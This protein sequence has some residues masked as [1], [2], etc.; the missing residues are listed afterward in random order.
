MDWSLIRS[1]L[2]PS[3]QL[4]FVNRFSPNRERHPVAQVANLKEGLKDVNGCS[5]T[6][7]EFFRLVRNEDVA[8]SI[9][10]SS[11]KQIKASKIR[12]RIVLLLGI[13]RLAMFSEFLRLFL[14]TSV[15]VLLVYFS[16]QVSSGLYRN[17]NVGRIRWS[18]AHHLT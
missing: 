1:S 18:L 15:F 10:V 13:G 11:T 3:R 9:S 4:R 6:R 16:P 2:E 12:Y 7:Y 17:L 5:T 8:G 14:R